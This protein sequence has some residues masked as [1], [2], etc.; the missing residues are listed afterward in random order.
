MDDAAVKR[1]P[2]WK[3]RRFLVLV[4]VVAAVWGLARACDYRRQANFDQQTWLHYSS[5]DD[6]LK[7]TRGA[8]V[9]DLQD[10]YLHDSMTLAQVEALLGKPD[11]PARN[12]C[13]DYSL[14]MCSGFQMDYDSLY[15]CF[16]DDGG[17]SSSY[18]V[19]H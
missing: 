7:C 17:V 16:N 5:L 15:V 14:G 2:W 8:M 4:G 10:R 12:G 13:V 19:Q 18:T 1:R 3:R 6:Q 11:G 9:A